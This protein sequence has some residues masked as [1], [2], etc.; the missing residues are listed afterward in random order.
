M[1]ADMAVSWY[2]RSIWMPENSIPYPCSGQISPLATVSIIKQYIRDQEKNG[3]K[4]HQNS[5]SSICLPFKALKQSDQHLIKS[6]R[7]TLSNDSRCHSSNIYDSGK[8]KVSDASKTAYDASRMPS[9]ASRVVS[10]ASRMVSVASRMVSDSSRMVSDSSRMSTLND[11]RPCVTPIALEM[12]NAGRQATRQ[13]TY[14]VQKGIRKKKDTSTVNKK[15]EKNKSIEDNITEVQDKAVNSFSNKYICTY[16][17]PKKAP[18]TDVW[19]Y[20]ITLKDNREGTESNVQGNRLL[21]NNQG[22]KD[23]LHP[24]SISPK[25]NKTL[26]VVRWKQQLDQLARA[27]MYQGE[28]VD[29]KFSRMRSK[30]KKQRDVIKD[31]SYGLR[32]EYENGYNNR[33]KSLHSTTKHQGLGPAGENIAQSGAPERFNETLSL[34]QG[35]NHRYPK[36]RVSVQ[37]LANQHNH[38]KLVNQLYGAPKSKYCATNLASKALE[39]A[40]TKSTGY[41]RADSNDLRAQSFRKIQNNSPAT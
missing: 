35:L 31:Y 7:S 14:V 10:D 26:D 37:S 8:R 38:R 13:N 11:L 34:I 23:K 39:V 17:L 16:R 32:K 41:A 29:A 20:S 30:T 5:I 19:Q 27:D 12:V 22:Y 28:H 21:D 24:A 15:V 2:N 3:I 33:S 9:E 4:W 18:N 36:A 40:D 1:K 6:A 25:I